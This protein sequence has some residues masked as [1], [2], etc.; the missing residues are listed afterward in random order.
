MSDKKAF[1]VYREYCALKSHFNT[2]YDYFKYEGKMRVT[3]SSFENRN[4]KPYFYR[5]A[6]RDDYDTF[7]LSNLV[8]NSGQWIGDLIEET[9]GERIHRDWLT[10]T[11]S[12]G[13]TFKNEIRNMNDDFDSNFLVTQGQH[14]HLLRLFQRKK[15]SLETLVILNDLV[16]FLPYWEKNIADTV[17]WPRINRIV[18][19]YSPFLQYDRH[20]MKAILKDRYNAYEN[21][22]ENTNVISR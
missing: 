6:K 18:R 13:Y 16:N 2:T 3:R 22:T 19:K 17:L 11:Q 9:K 5:L 15:V 14:P 1:E 21:H 8:T 20:K 7:L 12:M 4:D 10:R